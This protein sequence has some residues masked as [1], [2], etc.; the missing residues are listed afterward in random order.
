MGRFEEHEYFS[1][2]VFVGMIMQADVTALMVM[3]CALDKRYPVYHYGMQA[4]A[5]AVRAGESGK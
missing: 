5:L 3:V 4:G 2:D 1:S